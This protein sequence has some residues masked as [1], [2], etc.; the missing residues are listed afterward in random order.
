MVV[1]VKLHKKRLKEKGIVI[2]EVYENEQFRYL[3]SSDGEEAHS[4]YKASKVEKSYY[5]N[6][7]LLYKDTDFNPEVKYTYV[8]NNKDSKISCSQC[9]NV[10]KVSDFY[11]GCPYCG[12]HFNIDYASKKKSGEYKAKEILEME[13]LKRIYKIL[14]FGCTLFYF[15]QMIRTDDGYA[16]ILF[17]LIMLPIFM[18][19]IYFLGV[20][21]A[22]P[23]LMYKLFN[24]K[25]LANDIIYIRKKKM[26]NHKIISDLH[27]ELLKYYYD[28]K[29][30]PENKDLIDFEIIDYIKYKIKYVGKENHIIIKFKVRKYFFKDNEFIKKE[31]IE[32]VT[33]KQNY[34]YVYDND[35]MEYIECKN[36]GAS[37]DLS[38]QKCEYCNTSVTSNNFW[39]LVNKS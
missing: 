7:K 26:D 36:C 2:N 5:H 33:L 3:R 20:I 39:V 30:S 9:G 38:K 35:G 8:I 6:N 4:I 19:M 1:S 22:S 15:T 24:Y 13:P 23:Y 18:F 28:F 31:V 34:N 29:V 32:M 17:T 16:A 12:A 37:I 10:G 11:D 27:F 14:V 21:I 25:D